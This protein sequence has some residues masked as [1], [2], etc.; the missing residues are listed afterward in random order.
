MLHH[1]FVDVFALV[2]NC[3][4]IIEDWT[5]LNLMAIRWNY[6]I[7][8]LIDKTRFVNDSQ[9]NC[10]DDM[11]MGIECIVNLILLFVGLL[12]CV[13]SIVGMQFMDSGSRF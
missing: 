3:R 8:D 6:A 9:C 2:A 12:Q 10:F 11:D 4:R 13:R 1:E 7:C 5:G